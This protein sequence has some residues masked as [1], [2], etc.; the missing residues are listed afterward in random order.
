MKLLLG[1]D[2][3]KE[4]QR[5]VTDRTSARAVVVVSYFGTDGHKLLPLRVGDTLVVA[6]SKANVMAGL[7]NPNSL[8]E[9]E[10]GVLIY[11]SRLLHGKLYAFGSQA[12]IGSA[13]VSTSSKDRLDEIATVV[14]V[15]EKEVASVLENLEK[16]LLTRD[17]LKTLASIYAPPQGAAREI[18]DAPTLA[19]VPEPESFQKPSGTD[20]IW[21]HGTFNEQYSRDNPLRTSLTSMGR[22]RVG[23][24]YIL[25]FRDSTGARQAA[26]PRRVSRVRE[27][28]GGIDLH[29]EKTPLRHSL[30][31]ERIEAL[32]VRGAPRILSRWLL[33]SDRAPAPTIFAAFGMKAE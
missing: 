4:V 11:S 1:R 8:L 25:V 10:E 19:D 9:Y 22:I 14:R 30:P 18:V 12:L 2:V 17:D 5:L 29:F 15:T 33:L 23:D 16:Q 32:L 20:R 26:A 27:V 13:N 31:A 3:W 24:W 7:V 21:Y 6:A 28:V